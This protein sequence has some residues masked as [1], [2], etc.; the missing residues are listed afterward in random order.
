MAGIDAAPLRY[1]ELVLERE[2]SDRPGRSRRGFVAFAE[3]PRERYLG[4]GA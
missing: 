1:T 4:E 2:A 3:V